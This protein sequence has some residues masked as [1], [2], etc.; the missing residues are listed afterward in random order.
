MRETPEPVGSRILTGDDLNALCECPN[1][2][3]RQQLGGAMRPVIRERT[4]N[5]ARLLY[6]RLLAGL[7]PPEDVDDI[8]DELER[9]ID[10]GLWPWW[11]S[12]LRCIR[13][14]I[15]GCGFMPGHPL[16]PDVIAPRTN[17][18]NVQPLFI[19]PHKH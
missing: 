17:S 5:A 15:R 7:I 3:L 8:E 10:A 19:N 18:N 12:D 13:L 11:K 6:A 4:I 2:D 16:A 9:V 14:A 1:E